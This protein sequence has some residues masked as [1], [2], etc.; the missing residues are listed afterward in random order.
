M[1]SLHIYAITEAKKSQ[2]RKQKYAIS[3]NYAKSGSASSRIFLQGMLPEEQ[4]I[5]SGAM[6]LCD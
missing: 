2:E 1:R 6:H 3:C 4:P 5:A